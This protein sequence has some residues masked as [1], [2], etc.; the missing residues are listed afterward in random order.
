MKTKSSLSKHFKRLIRRNAVSTLNENHL[1]LF[2]T[3]LT[4]VEND[5]NDNLNGYD[6]KKLKSSLGKNVTL[7]NNTQKNKLSIP[8]IIDSNTVY[9]SYSN[10]IA[11]NYLKCLRHAYAHNYISY[12]ENNNEFTIVLPSKDKT[13]IRLYSRMSH[14]MLNKIISELISQKQKSKNKSKKKNKK[15]NKN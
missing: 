5:E 4:M 13:S 3:V 12:D 7:H 15:E 2:H 10:R 9:I 11:A 1:K 14:D 8:D 6:W